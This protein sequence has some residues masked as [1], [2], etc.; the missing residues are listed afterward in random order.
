MGTLVEHANPWAL[1][2]ERGDV[3]EHVQDIHLLVPSF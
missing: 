3:H 2:D 1:D